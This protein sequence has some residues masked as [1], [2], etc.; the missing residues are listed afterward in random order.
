MDGP[1]WSWS[2]ACISADRQ[3][4]G[5]S[6]FLGCGLPHSP[7]IHCPDELRESREGK[8]WAEESC[9]AEFALVLE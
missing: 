5:S 1:S 3:M 9:R 2:P 8:L 6:W 7:S 4:P